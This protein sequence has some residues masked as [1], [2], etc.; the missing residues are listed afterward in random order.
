MSV[1]S[2]AITWARGKLGKQVGAGECWD[3]AN[4]AI[5]AAGGKGSEYYGTIGDDVDYIW[6][7]AVSL[8]SVQAGDIIQTRDHVTTITTKVTTTYPD[9]EEGEDESYTTENRP[10]HTAI[11]TSLLDKNGTLA[12]L[13]QNIQPKDKVVQ[14]KRLNTRDI[15]TVTTKKTAMVV[16]PRNGKK[17]MAKIKT[18][19]TVEVT[20]TIWA[21]R[22]KKG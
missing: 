22:P 10:H 3:L 16:D 5:V 9:G 7:D 13:E 18:E 21:Y 1:G 6:G 12:T 2:Q 19:V 20:G 17:V 15:D 4:S 14:V 8:N 11:V